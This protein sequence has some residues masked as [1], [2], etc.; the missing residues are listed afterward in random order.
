MKKSERSEPQYLYLA[1]TGRHSGRPREIEI[2]FTR[3][4]G[5][6]YLISERGRRA[7]WVRNLAAD[8]AARVKV[9][10]RRFR[11]RARLVDARVERALARA[12]R[13][14]SETKY[15]WSDG[16]VVELTPLQLDS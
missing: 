5:R 3:L 7:H 9:G 15:G 12:V 14:L 1:T 4:D 2:W 11:A 10:R 6:Y 13:R 8:S 16:L